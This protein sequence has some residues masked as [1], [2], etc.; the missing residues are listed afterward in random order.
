MSKRHHTRAFTLIEL[1]VVIAIIALLIGILLPAIGTARQTAR[2]IKDGTQIRGVHQGMVIWAQNNGD[3]FPLPSRIDRLHATLANPGSGSEQQKDLTRHI[4]SL[5][6]ANGLV[7]PQLLVGPAEANGMVR[8][9]EQYQYD[10]PN[11]A[12][13]PAQAHW[14]PAFR[15]TP[16]DQQIG[17]I[18]IVE[19]ASSYAHLPPVG[20]R[21]QRWGNTFAAIEPVVGNR[22]PLFTPVAQG[23]INTWQLAAEP[24][25]LGVRSRTL[26][27]HGSRT[28]WNGNIA[29]NDGRIEF[30]TRSDPDQISFTFHGLPVP[31]RTRADNIFINE[32]D[33]NAAAVAGHTGSFG[34]PQ[35]SSGSYSDSQAH[36]H[37]NAY[38]RV[39]SQRSG[40][41]TSPTLTMWVD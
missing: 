10:N 9:W 6:I 37:T 31:Q 16:I 39:I 34:F 35:L 17:S 30:L 8:A 4:F 15:A 29:F 14:D 5:M 38:L 27:I 2:Q 25:E 28:Q 32:N 24:P 21:R 41:N 11:A 1:L 13:N 12:V 40:L 18:S 23:G 19:G 3:E 33:V 20:H 36:L 22:G 7:P 26:Q